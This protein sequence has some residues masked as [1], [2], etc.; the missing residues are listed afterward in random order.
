MSEANFHRIDPHGDVVILLRNPGASFAV[1]DADLSSS[2]KR[3]TEPPVAQDICG[4]CPNYDEIPAPESVPEPPMEEAPAEDYALD[5]WGG[6]GIRKKKKKI[7]TILFNFDDAETVEAA[8]PYEELIPEA[9]VYSEPVPEQ[10]AYIEPEPE[11]EAYLEPEPDPEAY[12]RLHP[13]PET[14]EETKPETPEELEVRYLV[15]S[16]HLALA[17]RYFSTKLSGPWIEASVRVIDGCYHMEATDWDP[18]ALLILMQIIHGKTRSVPRQVDF[19]MLAKLAVLVDYYDC[20]EVIEVFYSLWIEPLREDLPSLYCRDSVLWLLISHVFREDAIFKDMTGLAVLQSADPIQTME[21]PIP[22]IVVDL[23]DW[24]RQDAVEF[25]FGVLRNLLDAFRY[26]TAGCDFTCSSVLFGALTKEMDR[27][28]LLDPKPVK[29][30]QGYSIEDTEK[31]VRSFRSPEW[32]T[33][34]KQREKHPCT[35][36]S[37]IECYLNADF[38]KSK[39]GFELFEV[40]S[41]RVNGGLNRGKGKDVPAD[42]EPAPTLED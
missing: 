10:E 12:G 24:R 35:L 33:R 18:E 6:F 23:V 28:E 40:V 22:S 7:K 5:S 42:E 1:W 3:A 34:Y 11:Q 30:Y 20:H 27:Y 2:R 26:D 32:R 8:K 41:A 25:I 21:L 19:E 31:I 15:S 17:S 29:P 39:Q 9:E 4:S 13:E 36:R 16:R 38:D 37:M 14:Y